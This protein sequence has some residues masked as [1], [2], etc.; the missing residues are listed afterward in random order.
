VLELRLGRR[1]LD[2]ELSEHLGAWSVSEVALHDSYLSGGQ[3]V[4]MLAFRSTRRH[5][6]VAAGAELVDKSRTR[7]RPTELGP[8]LGRVG[9]LIEQ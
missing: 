3:P 8:S 1:Q 5:F 6:A 9:A 7:G 4:D 2:R